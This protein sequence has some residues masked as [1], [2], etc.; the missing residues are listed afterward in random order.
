VLNRLKALFHDLRA[1]GPRLSAL[2]ESV[3]SLCEEHG[4][5]RRTVGELDTIVREL[6]TIV[7][8]EL[9][10]TSRALLDVNTFLREKLASPE[11]IGELTKSGW[12]RA[13]PTPE[14]TWN[15]EM[16]G[17]E[18]LGHM[19]KACG[20]SFDSIVEIGPGYGRVLSALIEDNVRFD[21][22]LGLDISEE[23]V[24]HLVAAFPDSRLDFIHT[25]FLAHEIDRPADLIYSSAVFLHL[26][27]SIEPALAW[28]YDSL[29]P[30]G[31]ICFDVPQGRLRYVDGAW[32]V[33]VH[34]YEEMELR[35]LVAAAGFDSC[36]VMLE[37]EFAPM[38]DGWF[39]AASKPVAN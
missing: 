31:H 24:N 5:T 32:G 25:D 7:R 35:S 4:E 20:D 11:E 26:Y 18:F 23:N 36:Q 37:H 29:A 30:G 38:V 28:C 33:F 17:D 22:Y 3:D 13:S 14:L 16:T 6:N 10:T 15:T 9:G 21:H 12:R 39:V 2:E 19:L 27:P 1:Q 34:H 8:A